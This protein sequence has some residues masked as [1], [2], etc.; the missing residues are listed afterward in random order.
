MKIVV[1]ADEIYPIEHVYGLLEIA[2][3]TASTLEL[4]LVSD[5]AIDVRIEEGFSTGRLS[6][7]DSSDVFFI[8]KKIFKADMVIGLPSKYILLRVLSRLKLIK[9]LPIYFGPGKITKAIGYYKHPE[10]S[11]IRILKTYLKFLLLNTYFVANDKIDGLY[12]AAALGYPLSRVAI[13]PL[14]KY[15]YINERLC[16]GQKKARP[17]GILIA[18]THR[19]GD[20]IPPLTQMCASEGL[21]RCFHDLNV[22]IFHSK[23]PESVE[24]TLNGQVLEYTG[25][26][27]DIDILVTDYS[28]IGDD[29]F[30]AGGRHLLYYVPD[31][32]EFELKQGAGIFFD[33][34]LMLGTVHSDI[35]DLIRNLIDR[36]KIARN[37]V[38]PE[39]DSPFYFDELSSVRHKP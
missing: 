35:D 25:N 7:C 28:S 29:F 10:N 11:Q 26:W 32:E 4:V 38:I 1:F 5:N 20:V 14:P 13:A 19:W 3:K 15:F 31:R 39:M 2:K 33:Q 18:P 21:L 30:N 34:S 16:A 8:C 24:I 37:D 36:S 12:N 27:D 17:T 22:R 9:F 6:R 23:H